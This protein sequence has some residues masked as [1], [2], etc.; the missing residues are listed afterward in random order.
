MH[1][2]VFGECLCPGSHHS[3]QEPDKDAKKS[4]SGQPLAWESFIYQ[5]ARKGRGG[6]KENYY[7]SNYRV[8]CWSNSNV[9]GE[10]NNE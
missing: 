8:T 9:K 3:F 1:S 6:F 7:R 5:V 10:S 4:R 2:A